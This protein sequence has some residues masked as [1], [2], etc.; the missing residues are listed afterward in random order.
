MVQVPG[1]HTASL[2]E[3]RQHCGSKATLVLEGWVAWA[4][5]SG[6]WEAGA[7]KE[8]CAEGVEGEGHVWTHMT[9][10]QRRLCCMAWQ[11]RR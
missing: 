7:A 3:S 1:S 4:V 9:A 11:S 10:S 6:G 2:Q 5:V 8:A